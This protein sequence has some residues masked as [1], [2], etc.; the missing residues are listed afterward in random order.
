MSVK[1][2]LTQAFTTEQTPDGDD[3]AIPFVST[4][5]KYAALTFTSQTNFV[6]DIPT[7]QF[8][9]YRIRDGKV[10]YNHPSF[11]YNSKRRMEDHNEYILSIAFSPDLK[12]V[13]IA[14][15][16]QTYPPRV[17]VSATPDP[18]TDN[19]LF[20]VL[21]SPTLPVI[22]KDSVNLGPN[23][24]L[25]FDV[26]L[27]LYEFNCDFTRLTPIS[28]TVF[29]KIY[30]GPVLFGLT[31]TDPRYATAEYPSGQVPTDTEITP[32]VYVVIDT[33]RDLATVA[34][35]E[36]PIF[37]NNP[38]IFRIESRQDREDK[39]EK[40][41]ENKCKDKYYLA[42]SGCGVNLNVPTVLVG[43]VV[44]QNVQTPSYVGVYQ[45]RRGSEHLELVD[46]V[47][48]SSFSRGVG[49]RVCDDEALIINTSRVPVK[50]R[51]PSTYTL[52][53]SVN[54]SPPPPDLFAYPDGVQAAFVQGGKSDTST[55]QFLRFKDDELR[56]IEKI[57]TNKPEQFT[58]LFIPHSDSIVVSSQFPVS[59]TYTDSQQY[60]ISYKK[61][62][63]H[64][65]HLYDS[66]HPFPDG[67][68]SAVSEREKNQVLISAGVAGNN[69]G[70]AGSGVN[71]VQLFLVEH[72]CCDDS[73]NDGFH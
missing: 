66:S 55:L 52:I 8:V 42:T 14:S 17:A 7:D 64:Y 49:V 68:L 34:I 63:G 47:N 58:P 11:R 9:V 59:G 18:N 29:P 4:D 23:S 73:D 32:M 6:S 62:C 71:N 2:K 30:L 50:E 41:H 44:L 46:K 35:R 28:S 69:S 16:P 70:N 45:F 3:I 33:K 51:C 67:A 53:E 19:S 56:V 40:R 54:Q 38:T 25:T 31:W 22:L 61:E 57:S 12:R 15:A 60:R 48:I 43:I 37:S 24:N 5:G 20:Y 10:E 39:C 36:L 72:L 13:L 65:L 26:T 1:L 21:E 27:R